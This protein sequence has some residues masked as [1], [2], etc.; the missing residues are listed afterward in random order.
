MSGNALP[1][2]QTNMGYLEETFVQGNGTYNVLL[3]DAPKI[4][5]FVTKRHKHHR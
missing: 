4:S 2:K 3:F 5:L 1:S